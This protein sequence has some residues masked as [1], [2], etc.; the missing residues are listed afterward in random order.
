MKFR[1]I[2]DLHLECK[3]TNLTVIIDKMKKFNKIN[4]VDYLIMAGDITTFNNIHKLDSF[5]NIIKNDYLNIFYILGNH[6]FWGT[7]ENSTNI[8]NKYRE[9]KYVTVL[10][11]EIYKLSENLSIFGSTLWT[12]NFPNSHT[13]ARNHLQSLQQLSN[14]FIVVTHHIPSLQLIDNKYKNLDNK[15]FASNCEDVLGNNIPYFFHGHSHTSVNKVVNG[16]N[17]VRNPCG[18]KDYILNYLK[19]KS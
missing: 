4:K 7:K 18:N 8:I 13:S 1:L 9:T 2:S 19:G 14:E 6:E 15:N 11:N 3:Y 16:I 12:P 5:L 17:F 10:E